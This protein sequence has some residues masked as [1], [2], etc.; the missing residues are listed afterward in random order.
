MK[1]NDAQKE[2]VSELENPDQASIKSL[3]DELKRSLQTSDYQSNLS[4]AKALKD[5]EMALPDDRRHV[6]QHEVIKALLDF[7]K[8]KTAG[9]NIISWYFKEPLR[10]RNTLQFIFEHIN[11]FEFT[12]IS[13][14][15]KAQEVLAEDLLE[16]Y[17]FALVQTVLNKKNDAFFLL[18]NSFKNA[19]FDIEVTRSSLIRFDNSLDDTVVD[20]GAHVSKYVGQPFAKFALEQ[21]T[22]EMRLW[23]LTHISQSSDQPLGLI[24][25]AESLAARPFEQ[26]LNALLN[27]TETYA[28]KGDLLAATRGLESLLL[29]MAHTPA[30]LDKIKYSYMTGFILNPALHE[31]SIYFLRV[32]CSHDE[33]QDFLRGAL[34]KHFLEYNTEQL[35]GF[36]ELADGLTTSALAHPPLLALFLAGQADK[37]ILYQERGYELDVLIEPVTYQY[38]VHST[39]SSVSYQPQPQWLNQSLQDVVELHFP[40]LLNGKQ[41]A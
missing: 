11:Y 10:S 7:C 18:I 22:F 19:H 27:I 23:A 26:K 38:Y 8:D 5:R 13:S 4:L 24:S 21:G 36:F 3:L 2:K 6:V 1:K 37:F 30:L 32:F 20:L 15:I 14:A 40:R 41:N 16:A 35:R 39:V 25:E 28:A 17:E 34:N 29:S 9:L 12:D 31:L 33:R